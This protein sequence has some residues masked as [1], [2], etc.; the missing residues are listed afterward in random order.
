VNPQDVYR[1]LA[2]LTR[3]RAAAQA[4]QP[5]A[6]RLALVEGSGRLTVV[7]VRA[8]ALRAMQHHGTPQCLV[9]VDYL[10]LWAKVAE[11]LRGGLSVRERVE[12]L[13]G[14]LRELAARLH[15]RVLALASQNRAQRH[16]GNGGSVS[17]VEMM[18]PMALTYKVLFPSRSTFETPP[19]IPPLRLH[20]APKC[21][22][23]VW[24][25]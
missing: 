3:L 15:S 11:E 16:Y 18:T 4:R 5:V 24:N 25:Q 1:G 17:K 23:G 19:D 21:C 2:D 10:Q 7:Q 12:L 13:G 14:A 6:A 9:I 20:G 22:G 8:Q